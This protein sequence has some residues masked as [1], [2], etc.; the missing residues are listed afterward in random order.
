MNIAIIAAAGTGSRMASDRPKQFLQLAGSPIIFHTLKPFELCES[1]QE[2]ILVLPAEESAAFLAHAGKLGLRKL[3]RVVPGGS[4]R[5]DSVKRG[6]LSIRQATAEIVAVHDGVRP[7]VTVEEIDNTVAAARSDGAAILATPATDTIKLVE[8]D[9]VV[10]T[11]E[12]TKLRQA[13]TPQCFRYELLRQAYEQ[14]D[15]NDPSLTDESA[16]VE[17]LGHKVTIVEGSARNIKITTP[18]DLLI[19]E[20]FLAA[21]YTD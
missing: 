1:I 16:L 15:V 20:T 18:R 13:L 8:G 7:F 14:A 6:L 11:L 2:V 3:A 9:V 19:A 17:R 21:D 12:R 5:A 4:T 10:K